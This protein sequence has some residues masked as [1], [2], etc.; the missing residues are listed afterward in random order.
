MSGDANTRTPWHRSTFVVAL[1]GNL[2]LWAALPPLGLSWLGWIAPVPWLLLV[3]VE[4]LPGRRPYA[5]VWLAAFVFWLLAI[6]WIRL[7]HPALHIGW[8]ALSAYLALFLPAFVGLSRVGLHRVGLPLWITAPVVFTGLEL[9]RAHLLTGFLMGSLAHSQV[10]WTTLIQIG[11]IAGEYGVDYVM[12]LVAACI[13]SAVPIPS[14]NPQSAIHNQQSAGS[15]SR[16]RLLALLP[17]A[18]VLAASLAY[19]NWRL[20]SAKPIAE[21]TSP[22]GDFFRIAL[23][24]GNSPAD[25]K[26]DMERQR[27][28]MDEY[29][30]LSELAIA[31]AKE[32]GDG[33][34]VDLVVWPETMFRSG[35]IS[36]DPDYQMPEEAG[37]TAEER[38]A[39]GPHDLAALVA[40]LSTPVLVGIDRVHIL[41]DPA[42]DKNSPRYLGYNSSA[43]VDRDGKIV[44]T[45]DKVH[46]VVFGEYMPFARWF[47]I[48]YRITV[49]TGG[50]ESGAGPVGMHVEDKFCISPSICYETAVPHV[51]RRQLTTLNGRS[52]TPDVLVNMTNDAWYWGSSELDLHLACG[53]FRAVETR[54]PLVVA[55]NGGIS[56]WVDRYGRILAQSPR[57]QS[58]VLLA[59]IE[60]GSMRSW[61]VDFGDWFAGV[62]LTCC[63]LLAII[64]FRYWFQTKA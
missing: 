32:R 58:D 47:P 22:K 45:Y 57:L 21:A 26:G 51:M 23:I 44:D 40:R 64:G 61:Y 12:I 20:E 4:R 43:L 6:H 19:G 53:I 37:M 39:I 13:A 38:A 52:E 56:A 5:A 27:E 11:D 1:A 48:L 35:L 3:R 54:T 18:I 60:D 50:V 14:A 30:R 63:V 33:H 9:A 24:Q 17:A 7:P 42:A 62:C 28:I 55:A 8:L 59:D 15:Q 31:K 25:W 16:W 34:G 10:H 29:I 2:L 49:L 36:F 46:L 41:A